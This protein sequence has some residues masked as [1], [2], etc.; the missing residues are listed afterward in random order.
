[1][2]IRDNGK[3][4]ASN[5]FQEWC[6][7]LKIKQNYTSVAHPQANRQ[8]KVTNQTILPGLKTRLG[9]AKGQWVKEL[10]NVLWAYRKTAHATNGCTPYSLVYGSESVLP[11]K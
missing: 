4:F 7:E 11:R 6:D 9:K 10:P 1:I 5:P 2:I 3:Q 8:T